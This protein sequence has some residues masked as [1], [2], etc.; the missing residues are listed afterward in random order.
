MSRKPFA[1]ASATVAAL[2]FTLTA[3]GGGEK[4][5]VPDGPGPLATMT[6][7]Q[8]LDTLSELSSRQLTVN[9]ADAKGRGLV[10]VAVTWVSSDTSVAPITADGVV[11]ARQP[12][13][14][15][16]TARSGSVTASQPLRIVAAQVRDIT[17]RLVGA[18]SSDTLLV[19]TSAT[20][21][22]EPRDIVGAA[23]LGRTVTV[24]I[25]DTA[26]GSVDAAGRVTGR[27]VGPLD[28]VLTSDTVVRRRTIIVRPSFAASM[29][30]RLADPKQLHD[31]LWIGLR[32]SALVTYSDSAGKALAPS[33]LRP[34]TYSTTDAK[35]ATVDA[36]GRI[37]PLAA[38]TVTIRAAGDRL[39]AARSVVVVAAPLAAVL[40]GSDTIRIAPNDSAL[41]RPVL[42]DGAGLSV[43][44]LVG[45]T[46]S[47][48]SLDAAR[49]TVSNQG[50]VRGVSPGLARVTVTVDKIARTVPVTVVAP[51]PDRGFQIEVRFVGPAPSTE[52]QAAFAAAKAQWERVIKQTIG[53]V[54][55]TIPLGACGSTDPTHEEVVRDVII[56]ARIDSIDGPSKILGQAGP[57][58]V[59]QLP[60][61]RIVPEVGRMA[62]DSADMALMVS[63]GILTTVVT[64]EM[65]HVLG[66]GT[67]WSAADNAG[68]ALARQTGSDPRFFGNGATL[69]SAGV[70][71]T[72]SSLGLSGTA[73]LESV[74]LENTGGSG[75]AGSHWRESVF[76]NELMTGFVNNGSNPLS[77]VTVQ[78]MADMGYVVATSAA[79]QFGTVFST[80]AITYAELF[81][82]S[83][84]R[85][86]EQL[87]APEWLSTGRGRWTRL[88]AGGQQTRQ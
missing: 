3:C 70:G 55:D 79:E 65:G 38:G 27:V 11:V 81:G 84:V 52:V 25:G 1:R 77:L 74:P 36:A 34:I 56:F 47:F 42:I 24:A 28:L 6:I 8:T 16:L 63:R 7:V 22:S 88:P 32:D 14:V 49:A 46:L 86:A 73:A 30:M 85:I 51:D 33:P 4:T 72:F 54:L 82:A 75:T 59:R 15:T 39:A 78:A 58:G 12:G 21:V 13:S 80:P 83:A 57:C 53:S 37:L 19:G 9:G 67:L 68:V 61:R 44:T 20:T 71:L 18:V 45:H 40:S 41:L 10:G 5:V 31:T 69:A 29:A 35:V 48:A 23:L 76:G 50:W 62:F 66:I 60:S 17:V 87:T 64:H 43:R 26:R 2:A